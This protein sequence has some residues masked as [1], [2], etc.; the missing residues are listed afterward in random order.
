MRTNF[1]RCI[2]LVLLVMLVIPL[3]ASAANITDF[4]D[5]QPSDWYYAAVDY[6]TSNGL[7]SGTTTT[8]FSPSLPMTRGMF[9]TVLGRLSNVPDSY[10]RTQTTPFNDVTQADYFFPYAVWANDT[11]VVTGIG[12]NSFNPHGEI[13][14]EQMAAIFF[15]YAE[16]FGYD[17]TYSTEKYIAFEDVNSVSNYAVQAMQ[18]A[19]TKG[20]ING[21][22]GKLNPQDSASRAQVAQIF[23]NFSQMGTTEPHEPNEP[24]EPTEPPIEPEEPIETPDWENYNPIYTRPTGKSEVDADGGYYDYDL[25]NEIMAQVDILRVNN[26]LN[27]LFY[28]PQIQEW[29]GVRAKEQIASEGHT[30]PDGALYSSVGRGLT[31][32]NITI[33]NNCT[34]SERNNISECAARAV[35]NWYTSTKGHKEAMLSSSSN[36]GAIACYVYGDTVCVVQLFS[37]KTLYYMDYLI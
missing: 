7:F 8:T 16:K 26:G 35:N 30:R 31:F 12:G 6:A 34:E 33:L 11:G 37:N 14:R 18:W 27:V 21:S 2:T 19:T 25:A 5:V 13:T 17:I 24:V 29:A 28:H 32:E 1:Y 36:L 3:G 23:L 15:R 22:G 4:T 20:V 10:G 9:V